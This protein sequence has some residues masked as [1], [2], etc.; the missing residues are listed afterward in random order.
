MAGQA[1]GKTWWGSEWLKS[2]T[3]IDYANRIPRGSAYARKGAVRSIEVKG[4]LIMA[5]VSG[6]RPTPYKVMIR[7]PLFTKQQTERLMK[8]LLKQPALISKLLNRE[9]DPEVF[10]VAKRVWL[11]L[12]PER[13]SDLDMKCSCPDWA[14]PCKH[15]AA[16]IYMMSREIDNDPFLVFSMHGVNLLEE[17]RQRGLTIDRQE[18]MEVP[19]MASLMEKKSP[20]PAPPLGECFVAAGQWDRGTLDFSH[21]QNLTSALPGLLAKEPVFYTKGDF[22]Q[23]YAAE[24]ARMA[25]EAE[26]ILA[27][28]R[29]LQTTLGVLPNGDIRRGD[30]VRLTMDANLT[31]EQ[32]YL[33][34]GKTDS[35]P[36]PYNDE[37]LVSLMQL[38]EDYLS[39]YDPSIAS[40]H[41]ALLCALQLLAHGAIVPQIV[42][43]PLGSYAVRWLPTKLDKEVARI[44]EQL[45]TLLPDD[46]LQARFGKAKLTKPVQHQAEHLLA[47]LFSRLIPKLSAKSTDDPIHTL[48]FKDEPRRFDRVGETSVPGNI[49]SW[50]DRFFLTE[51]EYAPS[52]LIDEDGEYGFRLDVAV[53]MDGEQV[54]LR[55]ILSNAA[56]EAS[57]FVILRE[58]SLL[59]SLIPGMDFYINSSCAAPIRFTLSEFTPFLLASI[60]AIR[61]L[62]VKVMLPKSLQDIIRPK[63]SM[64]LSKKQTDGKTYLRLDEMLQFDWQVALGDKHITPSEFEQLTRRATGLIRFKQQYIYVNEQDIERLRKAFEGSRPMTAA[65]MLQAALTESYDRAPIVLTDEV[66]QLIRQLTEQAEIPVPES[67]RATLRP[68]QERGFSWMYRNFRIGF[69]SIIADDMGLGKTLQVITLL[70][71]LKDDGILLPSSGGAGGGSALVVVPTGLV[72]N[73]QAEIERFAPQLSVFTYHG[74]WRSLKEFKDTDILLTTYGVLRSDAAKLKKLSWLAVIIDEAQNIKN[75]DTA[76]SKAVRSIPAKLHI[77]ISGTPVENRLSEFWSIMDFANQ[78]YLGS[79]KG[80]KEEFANPIQRQGDQQVADRFRRIT[81]PFLLRRLK[82]DKS[83]ISDLPDKIEQNELALLTKRQAALYHETLEQAMQAIEGIELA[84]HKSLFVRQGLVL[85]MILALKQICNHPALFLK[86]GDFNPELS[87]KTEMLLSLLESIVE[88]GQ[89]VLVFTQFREMGDMLRQMIEARLGECPLFL[90]GGCSI[91]ERQT[92]VERFQQNPRGDQI[93]LLSLKAAG[94]GLNLTAANHVIHYDLWWNPA[95]EAQATDRAYRIGQHQNVL[96]HRFITQNTFEERIDRMIQDKRHLAD[97]TVASDESWIGKL[98]NSELREIFR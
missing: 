30:A 40:L 1:F 24:V 21:L 17:L 98:S 22:Q 64:K 46:L 88:S 28:K 48:F 19:E 36:R 95:V 55:E 7:V 3:H 15:L 85:Q 89:K 57:R 75:A 18:I 92:M 43:L 65:Q 66:R 76:Q 74:S 83:I 5:K 25:R 84:D 10:R 77:A 13:W 29:E 49:R 73:W 87:G 61:L 78:S 54:R 71:K 11:S 9:L 52:L 79:A 50:T 96:V 93:F 67:I 69:G 16:V 34:E 6:S 58:L 62:G 82:S 70:Q 86:N 12:F 31:M 44:V 42:H 32:A 53:E 90:H 27:G 47:H 41:Q 81:A 35:R 45:E 20:L 39:D 4:N 38:P 37:F 94:T 60:P 2:L 26:R 91:K 33:F 23:K 14:V 63:V 59:A 68:Y 56:Y 8:E 97:M 72:T 80:F 51:R